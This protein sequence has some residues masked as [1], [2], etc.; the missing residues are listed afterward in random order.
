MPNATKR[1]ARTHLLNAS[2][3]DTTMMAAL[4]LTVK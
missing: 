4:M 1:T 3:S 2:A